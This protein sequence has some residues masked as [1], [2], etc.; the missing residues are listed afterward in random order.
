MASGLST[1]IDINKRVQ[2]Q[3]REL[4]SICPSRAYRSC[5]GVNRG[6]WTDTQRTQFSPLTFNG[7]GAWST[8]KMTTFDKGG[9]RRQ[10]GG[11]SWFLLLRD[12]QRRLRVPIRIFDD[13]D[14][15]YTGAVHFLFPG[16]YTL[17]GWLYYSDCHGLQVR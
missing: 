8:F 12:Y 2:S 11:D 10:R 9:A 14:G 7:L 6:T 1:T 17:W 16:N 13:G 15:T 4:S 3:W 5:E